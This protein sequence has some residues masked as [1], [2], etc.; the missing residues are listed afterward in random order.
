MPSLFD[1]LIK[2]TMPLAPKALVKQIARRYVA[3]ESV[4]EMLAVVR[5]LNDQGMMCTIDLLGEFVHTEAEARAAAKEYETILEAIHREKMDAGVSVKLTQMGLLLDKD[6]C[7]DI[8]RDLIFKAK[9]L[10][11]FVR[12]DMEDSGCTSDTIEIYLKLRRVFENVGIVL[13]AYLRR[14]L[15]DTR[16]ILAANAGNYRLCKGIYVEPRDI[17]FQDGEIT[18][19]N[20]ILVLKHMMKNNAYVGIATHDERLVWEAQRLIDQ[21]KV[22]REDYEFQM[23]L[24]VDE[25]LRD[26]ILASGHRLRVYVPYGAQWYAYCVR[27]LKENPKI[28]RYVIQH[29]WRSLVDRVANRRQ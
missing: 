27:R 9:E 20:F 25:E 11:V 18:N 8:M 2:H 23:L 16:D 14:T 6:L 15:G 19:R 22:K 12:I 24:G 10:G 5:R 28:A 29:L 3:G 4:E 26:I 7:V 1:Y 17:A 21:H 13:Q